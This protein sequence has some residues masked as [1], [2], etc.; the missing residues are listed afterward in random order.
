[1][2]FVL[3]SSIVNILLDAVLIVGLHMGA[4]GAALGTVLAQ[5]VAFCVGAVQFT[6][7][8]TVLQISLGEVRFHKKHLKN[9]LCLGFPRRPNE[10]DGVIWLCSLSAALPTALVLRPVRHMEWDPVSTVWRYLWM[11]P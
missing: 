3:I 10:V 4:L 1:M 2:S 8:N 9:I 5:F 6:H 7:G 11:E